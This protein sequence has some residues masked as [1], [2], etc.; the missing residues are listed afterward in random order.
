[1]LKYEYFTNTFFEESAT[2][3]KTKRGNFRYLPM[4]LIS[5]FKKGNESH[6]EKPER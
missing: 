4:P 5:N 2:K 1:M 6:V 3:T